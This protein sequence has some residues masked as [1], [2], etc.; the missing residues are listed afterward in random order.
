MNPLRSLIAEQG[1]S[2]AANQPVRGGGFNRYSAG[3]KRYGASQRRGPNTGM[4]LDQSGYNERDAKTR[5]RRQLMLE[6]LQA[7]QGGK[8]N[9]SA[10]MRPKGR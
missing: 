5:M 8:Y 7:Q 1:L 9:S 10:V 2:S 6:R 4:K 3:R